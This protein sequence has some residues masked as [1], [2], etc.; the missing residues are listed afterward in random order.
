[1]G[2]GWSSLRIYVFDLVAEKLPLSG[3]NAFQDEPTCQANTSTFT[4]VSTRTHIPPLEMPVNS[5]PMIMMTG[6]P[7]IICNTTPSCMCIYAYV[8]ACVKVGV[9]WDKDRPRC[10]YKNI[11]QYRS[12]HIYTHESLSLSI[13]IH[14]HTEERYIRT[15]MHGHIYMHI[16]YRP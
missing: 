7:A 3:V 6:P 12:S 15:H 2:I 14:I 11:C 1:M 13:Y 9:S 5:L 4:S 8:H 16:W 10:I